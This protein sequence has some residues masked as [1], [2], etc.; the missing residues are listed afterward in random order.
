[1]D[2]ARVSW[3]HEADVA[4]SPGVPK[5]FLTV[6]KRKDPFRGLIFGL[7]IFFEANRAD[8]QCD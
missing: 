5:N 6:D 7:E 8:S 1:M 4:G 3:S 2:G